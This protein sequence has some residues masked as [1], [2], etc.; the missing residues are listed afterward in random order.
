MITGNW[1]RVQRWQT[2]GRSMNKV[3]NGFLMTTQRAF[4]SLFA[5]LLLSSCALA[6][7]GRSIL[8]LNIGWRLHEGDTPAASATAFD[9]SAWDAIS[10]PHAFPPVPNKGMYLGDAWYRK[11]YTA[12][13][14]LKDRRVFLRFDAVAKIS[15]V[16]LNGELLGRHRGGFSAFTYEITGKLLLGEPNTIGVHVDNRLNQDVAPIEP[17][18]LNGGMY[19]SVSLIVTG[20]I[21]I[22]PMDFSAPGVYL[23]QTAVTPEQA[24][25]K[26]QTEVN[27]I[28]PDST[29]VSVRLLL[30]DGSGKPLFKTTATGPIPNA[31]TTTVTQV[32]TIPKPHLWNGV[33]DPYLYTVRVD[34]LDAENV[35]LDTVTQPLGLRFFKFEPK[36]GF[37]LNGA[38]QQIHGV[39]L[40]QDYGT[41]GWA[42]TPAQEKQDLE[43]L[44]EMGANGLRLVHYPHSQS[45]L[46][47]YDRTGMF[48]W[49]ELPMFGQV[50][51]SKE[52]RENIRQQLT[53]MI[54]QNY[55]HPSIFVWSLFNELRSNTKET[56][57]PIVEDLNKLA[58][59]E[60]PTRPT[61]GASHGDMLSNEPDTVKIPDL[62]AENDY[63]GWY[64]GSPVDML[65]WISKT[66]ASFD[67]RGLAVS[68]YGAGGKIGD[69]KQ[70]LGVTDTKPIDPYGNFQPEE[71]QALVHEGAYAS[72]KA[73]PFVWGSFI[74]L[75]FDSGGTPGGDGV[76]YGGNIKGL[77]TQ[78]RKVKK[79]AYF[80]YQANWTA[81][82]MLYLTSRRDTHR[83]NAETEVKVYSNAAE[84]T[85]KIN[86]KDLGPQKPDALH[87]FRWKK[88]ILSPGEDHLE[89]TTPE[90][91]QDEATWTLTSSGANK[92]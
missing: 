6:Q 3:P 17:S 81:K 23:T 34:L 14:E 60:D 41:V 30:I 84:V 91:L 48:I 92:P 31:K 58:H 49:S 7:P 19:R 63:A 89:V 45:A 70:G 32:I 77:V 87:I 82:P 67:G 79:D 5:G 20:A 72:I 62:I 16:Y 59:K 11:I 1:S 83:T 66:N 28:L 43:T 68:E 27:S 39:C 8:S 75:S 47:L 40:H 42:V 71:W 76:I 74:W 2:V 33:A 18:L 57:A 26:V 22:T 36:R 29:P 44:R 46:D 9:D 52:F 21:D 12:P 10:I 4:L 88:V 61:V 25:V 80:F 55:N 78:D 73:M 69:H 64:S 56:S 86:G 13:P 50:G 15:D 38:T 24:T 85:L 90:G 65:T 51:T 35:V 37:V 54:R 53:E